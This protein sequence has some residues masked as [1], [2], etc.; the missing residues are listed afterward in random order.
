MLKDSYSIFISWS[1]VIV[2]GLN[3]TFGNM[4]LK[5]GSYLEQGGNF[6]ERIF[7]VWFLSGII[8]YMVNVLLF[9]HSLRVLPVSLAYPVL[10][11]TGFFSLS[12]GSYFFL[13]ERLSYF[14]LFGIF[15][16]FLGIIIVCSGTVNE[17]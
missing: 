13:S 11:G 14:Q 4:L 10:A 1:F 8:F 5:K 2:A 6:P 15:V 17:E 16:I 3:S 9:Y 12:I 7:N